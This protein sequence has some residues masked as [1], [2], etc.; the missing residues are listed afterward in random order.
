M[1]SPQARWG[2]GMGSPQAR[3][4]R[5]MGSPQARW[6]RGDASQGGGGPPGEAR[7]RS[8]S[9]WVYSGDSDNA[10]GPPGP[11]AQGERCR[12]CRRGPDKTARTGPS[13]LHRF[14]A[15]VLAKSGVRAVIVLEGVNDIKG[16]PPRTDPA[17]YAAAYREL[18]RRAHARGLSVVGGTITPF[19]GHGGWTPARE[20]VR[21]SV[22]HFVRTSG[23][24]DAVADFDAAVRDPA[25]PERLAPAYDPG[26]HLHLNDAGYQAMADAVPL[27]V[28]RVASGRP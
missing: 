13:A 25:G 6:G 1:G 24:F 4:G 21:Q 8:S 7:G 23:V 2:R 3:W 14:D 16:S 5:G 19:G 15:D 17:V 27:T 26:D 20:A 10:G 11:K 9:Y 28:A 12:S 18:A 22:N